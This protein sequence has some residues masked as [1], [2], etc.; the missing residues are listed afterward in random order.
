MTRKKNGFKTS[1]GL[2][3]KGLDMAILVVALKM[4][5]VEEQRTT[6]VSVSGA[7]MSRNTEAYWLILFN[8]P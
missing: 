2:G 4:Q 3:I 6:Y 7:K 5:A 1:H 8:D